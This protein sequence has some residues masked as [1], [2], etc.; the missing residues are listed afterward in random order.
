MSDPAPAPLTDFIAACVR[1][2]LEVKQRLVPLYPRIA[3]AA[4]ALVAAYRRGNKVLFF[5]NGGSAADAQ[6]LSS[7]L[8][9]R[10]AFDRPPLCAL[11]LGVNT[12]ALTAV[13]NDLGA[14]QLFARQLAAMARPGDVAV[15]LST[16]GSSPNVLAAARRKHE[17]GLTLVALT[18]E[19]GGALAAL[20]DVL[21]DV[22]SRDTP[23]IQEAHILIGHVLCAWVERALFGDG[24]QGQETGVFR[25]QS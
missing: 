17:L 11:A 1:D 14:E 13:V 9:V 20:A 4:E 3:R 16:S 23:R 8:V 12:S 5:G 24:A 19:G 18:G 6:L 15:A 10:F 21:I 7:E 2:S 25:Q 22:P